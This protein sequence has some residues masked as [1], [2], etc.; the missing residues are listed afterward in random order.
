[1]N[2]LSRTLTGSVMII[3]GLVLSI[4]GFFFVVAWFYGVPI[5]IIGI[6]VFLNKKEDKIEERKDLRQM[7]GR[8]KE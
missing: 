8:K 6:F 3:L 5:L 4:I 1:M 7:K 2:T